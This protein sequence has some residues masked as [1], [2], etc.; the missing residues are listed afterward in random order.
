MITL[1]RLIFLSLSRLPLAVLYAITDVLYFIVYRGFGVN[2]KLTEKNLGNSFPDKNAREIRQLGNQAARNL[3][4]VGAEIIKGLSISEEQLRR[5]F[6]VKNAESV[7]RYF[8][9][10]QSVIIIAAHHCNWEWV[11][12][13]ASI[14]LKAPMDALFEPLHYPSIDRLFLNSRTRFGANMISAMGGIKELVKT[15]KPVRAIGIVGDQGPGPQERKYWMQFLNQDTAFYES[16]QTII[17]LTKSPVFFVSMK[18]VRRGFYE[19]QLDEVATPPYGK[20]MAALENYVR[21]L[22]AH[23]KEYPADWMW[24]YRRWRYDRG[25]DARYPRRHRIR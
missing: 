18:R 12:F 5:R 10:G 24:A 21:T 9:Q 23:I 4:N 17:R 22:E 11:L 8:D 13:A 19:I 14:D 16:I 15:G 7:N 1:V 6:S 20:D 3:L 25:I 2:R